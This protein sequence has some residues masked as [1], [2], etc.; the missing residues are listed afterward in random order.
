MLECKRLYLIWNYCQL[1][2]Q[3]YFYMLR[4]ILL[5]ENRHAKDAQTVI[6]GK[7]TYHFPLHPAVLETLTAGSAET[8]AFHLHQVRN[9]VS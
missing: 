5:T 7:R 3:K 9:V 4:T 8:P 1:L 2:G 6:I